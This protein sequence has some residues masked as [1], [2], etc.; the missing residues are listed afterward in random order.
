MK[1]KKIF[2]FIAVVCVL[3]LIGCNNTSD[4]TISKLDTIP[5]ADNQLY[6]V[7]YLGYIANHSL[8]SVILVTFF[9]MLRLR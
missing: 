3:T 4:E 9:L 8:F 7:A 5:F 2:I 6:A 1:I